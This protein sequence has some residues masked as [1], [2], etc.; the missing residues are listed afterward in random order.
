MI[1]FSLGP[2]QD[3]SEVAVVSDFT[4]RKPLAMRKTRDGMFVRHA[5]V[6]RDGFECEFIVD[7]QWITDPDHSTWT[8][9]R[10][11]TFNSVGRCPERKGTLRNAYS[12]N[13]VG[14]QKGAS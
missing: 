1:R 2:G 12:S 4:G 14:V 11:G 5:P 13:R 3:V 9:N 10:Y 6:S 8:V 7:G